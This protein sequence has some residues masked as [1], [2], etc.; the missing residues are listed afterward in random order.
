MMQLSN[1]SERVRK[2]GVHTNSTQGATSITNSEL[3][4]I[5]SMLT[6]RHPTDTDTITVARAAKSDSRAMLTFTILTIVSN[7]PLNS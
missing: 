6:N 3:I 4:E 2:L 7:P 5:L 1:I